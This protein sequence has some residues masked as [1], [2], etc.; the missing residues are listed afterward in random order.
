MKKTQIRSALLGM[1]CSLLLLAAAC[2]PEEASR[3]DV[4]QEET[5]GE[6]ATS[7]EDLA[8][9]EFNKFFPESDGD[10]SVVYTQEKS[11]FAE[12]V[13]KEN[14]EDVATLAV[15]DTVNNPSALDKYG[16][17]S[18]AIGGYPAAA[19]GDNGTAI[20]VAD[21]LQVQVRSVSDA[22]SE[23]D[24]ESWIQAF[25]LDGLAQLVQ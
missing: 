1:L 9:G 17:S 18:Q 22:F 24:R 3:W 16:E 13:L 6:R 7:A 5:A 19:V 12:A 10:F 23:G 2:A 15:S 8:G 14:G 25:D 4:V 20:L 21:R 11:G